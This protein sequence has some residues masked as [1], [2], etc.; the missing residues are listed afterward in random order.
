MYKVSS[1][2]P[3]SCVLHTIL[4]GKS[5]KRFLLPALSVATFALEQTSAQA[6]STA[7]TS[8]PPQHAAWVGDRG[9]AYLLQA[10]QPP[11]AGGSDQDIADIQAVLK[12][13]ATRTAAEIK[14]AKADQKFT[15]GL[16]GSIIGS[17]FTAENYPITFNFLNRVQAE[18]SYLN[19]LAQNKCQRHRPYQDHLEIINLFTVGRYSYPGAQAADS[20]ILT[21]V[22]AQ[23][24]FDK[25][26][27]LLNRDNVITQSGV[28]AGIN[29]PSDVVG[30]RA[31]AH[32]L[33]FIIQDNPAFLHDMG[34]AKAEI[35]AKKKSPSGIDKK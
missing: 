28:N 18:E 26:T 1:V 10:V 31:L 30:G 25:T 7:A 14:E 5:L 13:Q 22:L 3:R 2:L 21:L 24:F 9:T 32:S 15:I 33:M 27:D 8:P 4:T 19:L 16:L 23:L 17:D 6:V 20:R 34:Q 12:A 35:A 29:Y 11:P